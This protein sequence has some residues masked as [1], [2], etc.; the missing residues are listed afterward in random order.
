MGHLQ[1]HL[2]VVAQIHRR[3]L[4]ILQPPLGNVR[5]VALV[6][7]EE[8]VFAKMSQDVGALLGHQHPGILGIGEVNLRDLIGE[9]LIVGV[10]LRQQA[11]VHGH[12]RRSRGQWVHGVNPCQDRERVVVLGHGRG[13]HGEKNPAGVN[14]SDL[15]ALPCEGHRL[16]FHHGDANL[17]REQPHYRSPLH[18]GNLFQLL[19]PVV[20]VD[21]KDVFP[22]IFAEDRQHLR[23]AHLGQPGG[24][25]V[26]DP[27]NAEAGIAPQVGL[28][29]K[30]YGDETA[31]NH[32]SAQPQ[33][34]T[35]HRAGRPQPG[36]LGVL[37]P[38]KAHPT[39]GIGVILRVRHLQGHAGQV[40][41]G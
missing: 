35:A 37:W 21:K 2:L 8:S 12:P 40:A 28:E 39:R 5:L 24:L 32:E 26:A 17:V 11:F 16:P 30:A 33:K 38:A 15:L 20:E 10:Q 7:F 3:Q 29:K 18:P 34:H 23:A 27:G 22:D 13:R 31:Q 6:A 36:V 1:H 25:D 41:P 19:A 14:Q 9:V 4:G